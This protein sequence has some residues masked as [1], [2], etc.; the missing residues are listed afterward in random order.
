MDS[1]LTCDCDDGGPLRLFLL[2]REAQCALKSAILSVCHPTNG[3]ATMA[4]LDAVTCIP[5]LTGLWDILI[6]V[7]ANTRSWNLDT[8]VHE[9]FCHPTHKGEVLSHSHCWVSRR[10][11]DLNTTGAIC[12]RRRK[13]EFL[14]RHETVTPLILFPLYSHFICNL[15]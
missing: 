4:I 12:N 8:A 6:H 1:V 3:D 5:V 2:I 10:N 15:Y 7:Q 14:Q 13:I 9:W 11:V